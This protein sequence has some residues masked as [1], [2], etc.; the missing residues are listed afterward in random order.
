MDVKWKIFLIEDDKV[1]QKKICENLERWN[2]DVVSSKDFEKVFDDF[3]KYEPQLVLLDLTLPFYDGYYWCKKI[4]DYSNVPIIIISAKDESMSQIMAMTIGADDYIVKPFDINLLQSK[5]SALL[6]RSYKY[7][8][9]NNN[10]IVGDII[11]NKD[12]MALLRNESSIELSKNEFKIIEILMNNLSSVVKREEIMNC[13][14]Q[15][16]VFIDDNTLSV[17]IMRLRKKIK[18]LGLNDFIKTKKKVGYYIN[19]DFN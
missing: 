1:I 10:I 15:S 16:D 14:W 4:R 3:K 5:I 7:T 17:N 6:R 11:L 2:F 13:L 8:N 9:D 19:E 18:Q 12:L